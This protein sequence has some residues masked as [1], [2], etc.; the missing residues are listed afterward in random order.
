MITRYENVILMMVSVVA[1]MNYSFLVSL[2]ERD[3]IKIVW[4]RVLERTMGMKTSHE[5]VQYVI[6]WLIAVHEYVQLCMTMKAIV[7][8]DQSKACIASV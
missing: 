2:Y 3:S 8:N 1:S 4:G 6:L 5:Y 7:Y